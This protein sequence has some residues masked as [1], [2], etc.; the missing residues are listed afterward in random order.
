MRIPSVSAY[1]PDNADDMRRSAERVAELARL[2]GEDDV[3]P[4]RDSSVMGKLKE[5]FSGR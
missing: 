5:R 3:E 2:R 4:V 1:F